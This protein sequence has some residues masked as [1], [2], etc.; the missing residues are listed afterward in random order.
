[1]RRFEF[2][3]APLLAAAVA[4]AVGEVVAAAGA[5][6][7]GGVAGDGGDAGGVG[8]GGDRGSIAGVV[9]VPLMGLWVV[10]GFW[11]AAVQPAP[12][13]QAALIHMRMD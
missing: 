7:C 3:R 9:L 12:A 5:S 13:T 6:A 4:F 1:M 10:V 8:L 11:C 2:R